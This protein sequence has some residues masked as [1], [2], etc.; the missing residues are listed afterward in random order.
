[1]KT[2]GFLRQFFCGVVAKGSSTSCLSSSSK[3]STCVCQHQK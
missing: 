3:P 1:M 2:A